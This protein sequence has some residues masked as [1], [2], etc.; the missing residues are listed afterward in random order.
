MKKIFTTTLGISLA[1]FL[2]QCAPKFYTPAEANITASA[3]LEEL[4]KG[5]TLLMDKC[6]SCH[7]AP[8]PR[9]HDS[10]GWVTTLD[11]MQ[12]KAKIN[13]AEKALIFKY[14]TSEKI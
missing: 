12:P 3:T 11:N 2:S 1:L 9:K 14:L 13:D 8:S 4:N 10:S 7:G 6:G 5:K